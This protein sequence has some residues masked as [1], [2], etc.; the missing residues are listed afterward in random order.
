M[1]D[2]KFHLKLIFN[3]LAY[4]TKKE[5]KYS[6][7]SVQINNIYI[8][9]KSCHSISVFH[10]STS[11]GNLILNVSSHTSMFPYYPTSLPHACHQSARKREVGCDIRNTRTRVM[12]LLSLSLNPFPA[13]Y[14]RFDHFKHQ[15]NGKHGSRSFRAWWRKEKVPKT[16]TAKTYLRFKMS[17]YGVSGLP[18]KIKVSHPCFTWVYNLLFC[19]LLFYS[20]Q[21]THLVTNIQHLNLIK[22]VFVNPVELKLFFF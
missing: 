13:L 3:G 6:N 7:F 1:N 9:N 5:I 17:S 20:N 15:E 22:V 11:D 2:Y 18:Y 21:T 4:K 19:W 16:R 14:I 10:F 12:T 8:S